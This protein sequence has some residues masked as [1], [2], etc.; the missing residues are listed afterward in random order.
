MFTP[1]FVTRTTD[2]QQVKKSIIN[3]CV[4]F[5]KRPMI[6]EKKNNIAYCLII[7]PN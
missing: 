5:R 7:I 6:R 4:Y 1:Y 2:N 3:M